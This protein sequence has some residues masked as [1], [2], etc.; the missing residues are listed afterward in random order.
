MS[1][2]LRAQAQNGAVLRGEGRVSTLRGRTSV[3]AR[4]LDTFCDWPDNV[5]PSAGRTTSFAHADF[6]P[7]HRIA[8]VSDL[9]L[10]AE[11][12]AAEKPGHTPH[13]TIEVA[14]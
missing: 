13:L 8:I 2:N 6:A 5:G 12:H 3:T 10:L 7:S 4:C 9:Y 14:P 1:E 11:M